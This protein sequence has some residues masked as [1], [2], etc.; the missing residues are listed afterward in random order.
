MFYAINKKRALIIIVLAL[1]IISTPFIG[2]GIVNTVSKNNRS[3]P[4]YSVDTKENKIAISFDCAW[5]TDYTDKLLEVFDRENIKVTFFM[6]EFWAK[7]HPDLVKKISDKGHEIGTH[8][9]T[10]SYM[11]KMSEENIVKELNSSSKEIE[12]VTG[13]KIDLFRAPYGDYNNRLIDTAKSLGFYTIQWDVDSL[14]W[15]NLSS[16]EIFNRVVKKVKKGSI[17]LFHNNGLHTLEAVEKIIPYLKKEY[18]FSTI[19][20]LIYRENYFVNSN[21]VQIKK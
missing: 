20:E 8:S 21:G 5:G 14:D 2:G 6:V 9:S 10:H 12:S 17:V 18:S 1:F 11:S 19:G 16:D 15:K 13:K 7:K 4:I 3:L